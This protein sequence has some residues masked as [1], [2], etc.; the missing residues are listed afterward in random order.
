M[1]VAWICGQ[2]LRT[3]A[4]ITENALD[5]ISEIIGQF[6]SNQTM[7][8]ST[9]AEIAAIDRSNTA[10]IAG[11]FFSTHSTACMRIGITT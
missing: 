10:E 4:A 5:A 7:S 3:I 11:Q 1:I 2:Y 8:G 6:F 9:A